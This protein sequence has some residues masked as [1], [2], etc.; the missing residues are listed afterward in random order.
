VIPVGDQGVQELKLVQRT[1]KGY[2]T[3][4]LELVSFVPLVRGQT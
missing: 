4:R 3:E 1:D 2:T